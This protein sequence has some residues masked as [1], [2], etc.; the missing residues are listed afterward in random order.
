MKRIL[1]FAG[2]TEGRLIWN[3]CS[4]LHIPVTA[5]VAT[6]YG[7]FL[8]ENN[9]LSNV[10][11][12]RM[13]KVQMKKVMCGGEFSL[14]IDATHP[15]AIEATDNIK[16]ACIESKLEYIRIVRDEIHAD[17]VIRDEM[18]SS[19]KGSHNKGSHNNSELI[20]NEMISKEINDISDTNDIIMVDSMEQVVSYL[21]KN[22]GNVLVTTGSKEIKILTK[23]ID[24]KTRLYVRILP[25]LE[26]LKHCLEEGFSPSHMICMQG[27]FSTEFNTAT[28]KQTNASYLVTKEGGSFGGFMEKVEA[29]RNI[30]AKVIVVK[31]PS[32][33][34][35]ATLTEI[36]QILQERV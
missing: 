27:P 26:G 34:E 35:G 10:L 21:N 7:E 1:L 17:Q 20:S 24:Y 9:Q 36:F 15:Y 32:R 16:S 28:L 11:T 3:H 29:V 25:D 12:G 8:L 19:E 2:T 4:K 33:E 13:D 5:C 14:C 22:D 31:R 30:G 18:I 23:I 6:E